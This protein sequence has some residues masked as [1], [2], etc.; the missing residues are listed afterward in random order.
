MKG[1]YHYSS[2]S[3]VLL[4]E[5][6]KLLFSLGMLV[7]E[8]QLSQLCNVTLRSNLSFLV[9]GLLVSRQACCCCCFTR[10]KAPGATVCCRQQRDVSDPRIYRQ[11]HI[12]YCITDQ[13]PVYIG[14]LSHLLQQSLLACS[15]DCSGA[16]VCWRRRFKESF[17]RQLVRRCSRLCWQNSS[18]VSFFVAQCRANSRFSIGTLSS[19]C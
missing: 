3:V 2:L 5:F 18:D 11:C 7:R 10:S 12:C 4:A 19:A 13:N 1:T 14:A 17:G 8:G 15:V 16:L 6:F 9:P